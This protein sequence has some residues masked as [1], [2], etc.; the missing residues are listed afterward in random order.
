MG[1]CEGI[2]NETRAIGF[3]K[4]IMLSKKKNHKPYVSKITQRSQRYQ[5]FILCGWRID[6]KG[7]IKP[8]LD[9]GKP[10]LVR[11]NICEFGGTIDELSRNYLLKN[12]AVAKITLNRLEKMNV[13]TGVMFK[14][15]IQALDAAEEDEDVRVV[16]M[17]GNG[18]AFCAGVDLEFASKEWNNLKSEWDFYA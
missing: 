12:D 6:D 4:G 13:M 17:T 5:Y 3:K 7:L 15:I 16:V 14:E 10:G 2:S 18:K 9:N 8:K 1:E 11:L